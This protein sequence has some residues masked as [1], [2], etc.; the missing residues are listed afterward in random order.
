MHT[1]SNLY[2]ND[3]LCDQRRDKAKHVY[4]RAAGTWSIQSFHRRPIPII[5]NRKIFTTDSLGEI[6]EELIVMRL[7]RYILR[8]IL[9]TSITFENFDFGDRI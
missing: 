8:D 5:I 7:V 4:K 1:Q 6:F 2:Y 3:T 9:K